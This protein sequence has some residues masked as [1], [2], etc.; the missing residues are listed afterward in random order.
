MVV[1]GAVAS[2]RTSLFVAA[3]LSTTWSAPDRSSRSDPRNGRTE[4]SW[5][6]SGFDGPDKGK[7]IAL[8]Q[9]GGLHHRYVRRAA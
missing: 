1:R 2:H 8:P 3:P 9:V 7:V 5:E 6:P 4:P